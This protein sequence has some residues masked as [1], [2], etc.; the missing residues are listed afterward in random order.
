MA[1]RKSE[2]LFTEQILLGINYTVA[3]EP[4]VKK[5]TRKKYTIGLIDS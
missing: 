5:E 4:K 2:I 1:R 3:P